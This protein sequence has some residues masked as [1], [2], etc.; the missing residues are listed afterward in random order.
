VV[1]SNPS[2]SKSK[3]DSHNLS[4]YKNNWKW[5]DDSR[6]T[7]FEVPHE[8]WGASAAPLSVKPRCFRKLYVSTYCCSI[9]LLLLLLAL[10]HGVVDKQVVV[11]LALLNQQLL[12]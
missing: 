7:P 11:N 3:N 8:G 5:H 12:I 10:S 6:Q 9:L 4:K 2:I 1:E